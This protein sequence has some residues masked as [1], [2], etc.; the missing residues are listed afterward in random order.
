MIAPGVYL[1][2]KKTKVVINTDLSAYD[3]ILSQR[4]KD[5]QTHEMLCQIDNLNREVGSL[6]SDI[7]MLMK[8]VN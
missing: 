4:K 7:Q 3:D 1:K 8:K 5:R 6:R 2:D